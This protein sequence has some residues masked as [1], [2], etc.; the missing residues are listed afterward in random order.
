MFADSN[1]TPVFVGWRKLPKRAMAKL[2]VDK[3]INGEAQVWP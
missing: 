3:E 1:V 2:C